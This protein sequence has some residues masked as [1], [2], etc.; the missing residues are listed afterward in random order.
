M[1]QSFMQNRFLHPRPARRNPAREHRHPCKN[2]YG[3]ELSGK[4]G[5]AVAALELVGYGRRIMDSIVA[6]HHAAPLQETRK[7]LVAVAHRRFG[8]VP[9][10]LIVDHV[11]RAAGAGADFAVREAA[12]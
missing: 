9:G 4:F 8:S 10:E 7:T 2:T 6:S 12:I 1:A 11:L 3:A 5:R